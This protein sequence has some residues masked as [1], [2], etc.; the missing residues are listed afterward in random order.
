ME[1][2]KKGQREME[3]K[4]TIDLLGTVKRDNRKKT[5]SKTVY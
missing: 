5:K 3:N 2:S 1:K 4:Q